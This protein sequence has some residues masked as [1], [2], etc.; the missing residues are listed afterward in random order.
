MTSL[1]TTRRIILEVKPVIAIDISKNILFQVL[2]SG[3]NA[4]VTQRQSFNVD[5]PILDREQAK[6]QCQN[7]ETG[8]P[9]NV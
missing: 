9:Q 3:C 6:E 7:L 2:L 5:Q 8:I 4:A 1:Y